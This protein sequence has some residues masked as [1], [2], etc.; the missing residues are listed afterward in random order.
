MQR[1]RRTYDL[2]ITQHDDLAVQHLLKDIFKQWQID[3]QIINSK[4]L[5]STRL[6]WNARILENVLEPYADNSKQHFMNEAA[7]F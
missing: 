2:I 7:E 5:I 3:F 6:L 1:R 4:M